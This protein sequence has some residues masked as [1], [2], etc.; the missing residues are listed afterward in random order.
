MWMRAPSLASARSQF[1][2]LNDSI[3]PIVKWNFQ[4]EN[5]NLNSRTWTSILFSIWNCKIPKHEHKQYH[6]W[7]PH[8]FFHPT[9]VHC[10]FPLLFSFSHL[11][12]RH[13][14][15]PH[16]QYI[17]GCVFTSVWQSSVPRSDLGNRSAFSMAFCFLAN[18]SS[19]VLQR[20]SNAKVINNRMSL[21]NVIE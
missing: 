12:R 1:V 7:F 11:Y 8:F 10:I 9:D 14:Y 2:W 20:N 21:P 16:T 17:S 4:I 13:V 18:V 3:S 6:P 5:K 19:V 15:F